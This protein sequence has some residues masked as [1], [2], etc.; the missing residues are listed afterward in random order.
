M[1]KI[2]D[3]QSDKAN[4]ESGKLSLEYIV[5]DL[6]QL[7]LRTIKFIRPYAEERGQNLNFTVEDPK[8]F[9]VIIGDPFRLNQVVCYLILQGLSYS[10]KGGLEISCV[11]MEENESEK[12]VQIRLKDKGNEGIKSSPYARS[13]EESV[14]DFFKFYNRNTDYKLISLIQGH[15]IYT[16]DKQWQEVVSL[17]VNFKKVRSEGQL[18]PRDSN[19]DFLRDK[20]LLLAEEDK[21]NSIMIKGLLQEKGAE[22]QLC[23]NGLEVLEKLEMNPVDYVL[24]SNDLP[25]LDGLRTAKI[26]RE[27]EGAGLPIIGIF[28]GMDMVGAEGY[29]NS[30]INDYIIKPFDESELFEKLKKWKSSNGQFEAPGKE[31]LYDLDKLHRICSGNVEFMQNMISLFVQVSE[32]SLKEMKAAIRQQELVEV[33]RIAHRLK[34]SLNSMGIVSV[35]KEIDFLE[36]AKPSEEETLRILNK[37]ETVIGEVNKELKKLKLF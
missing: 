20:K 4:I 31:L 9:E 30:G 2:L 28:S 36:K 14:G 12:I 23:K 24:L 8:I 18:L 19:V 26:I 7:L 32:S 27:K 35:L 15:L 1:L 3:H 33:Q 29:S 6:N 22:V 17:E 13:S 16:I 10:V 37:L 25:L 34:P 21:L 5:F 11:L